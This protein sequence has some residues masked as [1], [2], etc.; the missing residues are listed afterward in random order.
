MVLFAFIAATPSLIFFI[1]TAPGTFDGS[2]KTQ[3][4]L[5]RINVKNC[6]KAKI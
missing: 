4:E 2:A 6:S 3:G 5:D 1:S